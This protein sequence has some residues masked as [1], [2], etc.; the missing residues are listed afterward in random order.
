MKCVGFC[1][2]HTLCY[3]F[4]PKVPR[5][6][7]YDQLNQILISDERLPENIILINTMEWQGQVCYT[8]SGFTGLTCFKASLRH[9]CTQKIISEGVDSTPEACV[10]CFLSSPINNQLIVSLSCVS[11]QYVAE[12]LNEQG[13]PI[14]ST[15]SAADVQ[16][17]FN[18][19]VTRIQRLWVPSSTHTNAHIGWTTQ[20]IKKFNHGSHYLEV[21]LAIFCMLLMAQRQRI[22]GRS[23]CSSAFCPWSPSIRMCLFFCERLKF[24]ISSLMPGSISSAAISSRNHVSGRSGPQSAAL[25]HLNLFSLKSRCTIHALHTCSSVNLFSP[26]GACVWFSH[27][28]TVLTIPLQRAQSFFQMLSRTIDGAIKSTYGIGHHNLS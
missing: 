7:V 9:Y 17:A 25:L 23:C 18:T 20:A 19:I 10:C 15:C 28:C 1:P 24:S 12:L 4:V 22:P 3:W 11:V 14:V 6:S 2:R 21:D 5:K 27:A 13:Q 8:G 16:A 26:A